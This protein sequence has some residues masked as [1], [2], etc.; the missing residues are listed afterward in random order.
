MLLPRQWTPGSQA[1]AVAKNHNN[2]LAYKNLS[3]PHEKRARQE[4]KQHDPLLNREGR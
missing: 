2:H 1:H 3:T 4:A